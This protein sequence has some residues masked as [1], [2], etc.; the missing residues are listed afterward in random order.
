M[1][2][3]PTVTEL[4]NALRHAETKELI[5]YKI[6]ADFY[7][8]MALTPSQGPILAPSETASATVSATMSPMAP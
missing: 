2:V 4:T 7:I 8:K 3:L 1:R 6:I 5:V